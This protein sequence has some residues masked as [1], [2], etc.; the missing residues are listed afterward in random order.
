VSFAL[1]GPVSSALGVRTTL[2]GAGVL[3]AV[4]T[5]AALLVP[6]VR[7]LDSEPSLDSTAWNSESDTSPP[8][9]RSAPAPL[10]G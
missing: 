3:G 5:F 1:T 10:L 7:R 2:I 6:G 4:V 8:T 9:T